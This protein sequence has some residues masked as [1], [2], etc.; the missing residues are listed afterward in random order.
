MNQDFV[1]RLSAERFANRNEIE[2]R[3]PGWW[4]VRY[5]F[6]EPEEINFLKVEKTRFGL[7]RSNFL[8]GFVET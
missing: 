5:A 7:I 6:Q 2:K 8:L 3:A 4:V 1:P